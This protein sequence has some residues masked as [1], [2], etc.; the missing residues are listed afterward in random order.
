MKINE[1]NE[2]KP[3]LELLERIVG[4]MKEKRIS[5]EDIQN[6]ILSVE[7]I[8]LVLYGTERLKF[9]KDYNLEEDYEY[10]EY[11]NELDNLIDVWKTTIEHRKGKEVDIEFWRNYQYFKY[12]DVEVI[13]ETV[14]KRFLSLPQRLQMQYLTLPKRYTFLKGKIDF[15]TQDFSLIREY[16][17]MMS[18]NIERYKWLYEHL[19][20]YRSKMVLNGIVQYWFNFN[21]EKMHTYS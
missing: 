4:V 8:N 16:V 5:E 14:L 19:A 6:V 2:I 11:A 17:E 9:Q 7:D 12:V 1:L 3:I 20:D 21:I 10:I 13:Y 18:N 15:I